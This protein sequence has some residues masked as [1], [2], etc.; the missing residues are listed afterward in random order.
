[1]STLPCLPEVNRSV[2]CRGMKSV[3]NDVVHSVLLNLEDLQSEPGNPAHGRLMAYPYEFPKQLA[4][5]I[6]WQ[7]SEGSTPL[8]PR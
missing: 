7:S 5:T 6:S 1:M 2:T 8:A 4:P 3:E